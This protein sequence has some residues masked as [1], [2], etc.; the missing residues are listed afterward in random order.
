MW[1][2]TDFRQEKG[3]LLSIEI[4]EKKCQKR[5][6]KI[7]GEEKAR[8]MLALTDTQGESGPWLTFLIS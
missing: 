5:E 2:K 3:Q 6:G 7:Y 4:Q 1:M 8:D